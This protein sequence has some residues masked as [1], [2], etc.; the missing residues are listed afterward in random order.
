MEHFDDV[1]DWVVWMVLIDKEDVV[2]NLENNI[3]G[4][5][6]LQYLGDYPCNHKM[7]HA[8]LVGKIGGCYIEIDIAALTQEYSTMD[9]ASKKMERK[10]FEPYM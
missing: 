4:V 3:D 8:K 1:V 2:E 9:Y 6:V 10:C 7:N 5:F